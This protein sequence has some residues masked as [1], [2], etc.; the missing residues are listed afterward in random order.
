MS[1]YLPGLVGDILVAIPPDPGL[2]VTGSIYAQTGSAETAVLQGIVDLGIDVDI[3]LGIIGATYTFE[4]P[5]IDGTY[6]IGAE[7]HLDFTANQ[8]LSKTFAIG[9]KGYIYHQVT[10]DSGSGAILGG[11]K[12]EAIGIGP[13]FIWLP[14]FADNRLAILGKWMTDV[15]SRRRFDSDYATLTASWNF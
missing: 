13:G 7:F 2:A 3:T 9:V 11:F 4:A 6:T 10:G 1:L 15:H 14:G 5:W 12:G 8:F